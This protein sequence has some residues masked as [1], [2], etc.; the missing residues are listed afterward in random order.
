MQIVCLFRYRNCF[1]F[2]DCN[3]KKVI[4]VAN[5]TLFSSI[6]FNFTFQNLEFICNSSIFD[7]KCHDAAKEVQTLS[8]IIIRLLLTV[9]VLRFLFTFK[10]RTRITHFSNMKHKCFNRFSFAYAVVTHAT[11]FQTT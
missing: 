3:P 1:N 6:K 11:P 8:Q 2:D 10:A 5:A 4:F 9:Y 7:N